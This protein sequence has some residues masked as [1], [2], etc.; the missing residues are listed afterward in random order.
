MALF[1][2]RR[3]ATDLPLARGE[4][5]LAVVPVTAEVQAVATT[6]RLVVRREGEP[7]W[8]RRWVEV[9]H[10]TWDDEERALQVVDVEGGGT[11]LDLVEDAHLVLAQVVRER[12]QATLVTFRAV[13]VPGGQVRVVL[14]KDG[15]GLVLQEVPG[16]GADTT[17]DLARAAITRTRSELAASVGL[18]EPPYR[19]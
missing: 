5:V 9:D 14:R 11:T 4:R 12:V 2:R 13:T 6:D 10:A 7:D 1:G 15:D 18:A 8:Q 3:P 19:S 17:S 16:P